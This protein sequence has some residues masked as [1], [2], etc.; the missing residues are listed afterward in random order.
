MVTQKSYPK[1][2]LEIESLQ[3]SDLFSD[4]LD[5]LGTG[6]KPVLRIGQEISRAQGEKKNTGL[7]VVRVVRQQQQTTEPSSGPYPCGVFCQC[8][9][10]MPMKPALRAYRCYSCSLD[11]FLLCLCS[12]WVWV[13]VWVSRSLTH[14]HTPQYKLFVTCVREILIR[15]Q[16]HQF[17]QN[18]H[19]HV[20]NVQFI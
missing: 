12:G 1:V 13:W 16:F 7:K 5:I 10:P 17:P 14:T 9:D 19:V 11:Y 6:K 15:V 8:T 2:L 20:T 3:F 18:K 4:R